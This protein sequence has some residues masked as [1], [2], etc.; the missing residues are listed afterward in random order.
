MDASSWCKPGGT[1]SNFQTRIKIPKI[2]IRK[3]NI[4]GVN[5]FFISL[6]IL[7]IMRVHP[8]HIL[9][10]ESPVILLLVFE[11]HLKKPYSLFYF[12][13][14]SLSLPTGSNRQFGRTLLQPVPG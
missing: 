8:L 10:I 1:W 9:F 7:W 12:E 11:S 3:N 6:L 14:P 5:I 2:K 4:T 13:H